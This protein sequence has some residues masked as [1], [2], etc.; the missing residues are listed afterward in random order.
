M[1][2]HIRVRE[3]DGQISHKQKHDNDKSMPKVKHDRIAGIAYAFL[4]FSLERIQ[5]LGDLSRNCFS[6]GDYVLSGI[7]HPFGR[8]NEIYGSAMKFFSGILVE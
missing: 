3:I 7:N 8:R 4:V 5:D 2:E 1:P 6:F